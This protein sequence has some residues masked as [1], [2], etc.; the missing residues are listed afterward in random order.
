M[1]L[2][3]R[4]RPRPQRDRGVRRF[5]AR[6][7]MSRAPTRSSAAA[8]ITAPRG[9]RL[10]PARAS[11]CSWSAVAIPRDRRRCSSPITR[12][13]H[14]A[15]AR[16][17]AGGQ[18]VA[19]PD[20]ATRH[21]EQHRGACA[22][23]DRPRRRRAP[24]RG[25]R[26][27]TPGP[28]ELV[29][30]PASAVFAF[31]G[32]DAKTDWLPASMIR[33]QDGYVCTGRDV[34]D[35]VAGKQGTWPL[36]R[37]PFL[38]ETSAPGVLAAGDV[39]HGSIKRRRLRRGRGQHGH[40]FRASIPRIQRG[41]STPMRASMN[42]RRLIPQEEAATV[43]AAAKPYTGIFPI[44][45]TPFTA[46]RRTGHR[47]TAARARL[48]DRPGCRRNLRPGQLFGA[49][50]AHGRR[51]RDILMD[52][53]LPTLPAA[54]RS[55]SR[56]SHFSTRIAPPSGR[57]R[58]RQ[59]GA[60]M[61]MLMPPYHGAAAACRRERNPRALPRASRKP[62]RHPD[63]G[64]GRTAERREPV[65]AVSRPARARSPRRC[66]ISR[67]RC[68]GAAGK[69]RSLVEAGGDAIAG[70]FDGEESITLDGR[71]R[72]GCHGTM[73]SAL[74]RPDQAGAGASPRG[75]GER[76]RR[77]CARDPPARSISRTGNADCAR[78]RP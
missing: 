31:I 6:S 9:P 55:S 3:G 13:G 22:L 20:P 26:R 77:A 48:H 24:P 7:W 69:L 38:L 47:R 35:L 10:W 21:Q 27:R 75:R 2:D 54:C 46:V 73:P 51:A 4:S 14:A 66:A 60:A 53:C 8:S 41:G 36:D 50:P 56:A 37:D 70:P 45:P 12:E 29:R 19:L 40:R 64:P 44:A 58:R 17:I 33:D 65:G 34:M 57:A 18:H 71:S 43:P 30:E 15:G 49:V 62:R 23:P 25:D 67:S 32:A 59:P 61:L 78:R 72:R 52:V 42:W 28:G 5:V 74:S 1:Q 11:T 39:R 76:C 16:T 68:R 63:H